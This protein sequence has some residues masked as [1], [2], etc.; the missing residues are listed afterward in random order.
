MYEYIIKAAAAVFFGR[1]DVEKLNSRKNLPNWE[2]QPFFFQMMGEM[3]DCRKIL[4]N[5]EDFPK[6]FEIWK[7]FGD[8]PK[9]RRTS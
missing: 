8:S 6:I 5:L 1:I 7:I 2:Q 9:D 4:R 3:C